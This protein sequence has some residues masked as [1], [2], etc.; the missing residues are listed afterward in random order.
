[1]TDLMEIARTAR[2]NA[3]CPYSRFAVGAALL[4][5][6]GSIYTGCNVENGAYPLGLCAER[7]AFVKAISDGRKRGDFKTIAI[8][9]NTV[10]SPGVGSTPTFDRASGHWEAPASAGSAPPC[11]ACRQVMAEF[12]DGDFAIILTDG[13]HTLDE[14]L[15]LRFSL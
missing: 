10:E 14:L 15:P 7:T 2:E 13:T 5:K 1:M 11:G 9:G 3:Y 4:C 8:C 12:C 6:D